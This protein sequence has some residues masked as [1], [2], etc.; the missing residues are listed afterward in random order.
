MSAASDRLLPIVRRMTHRDIDAVSAIEHQSYDFP[1]SSGIFR[2]CIL[3]GYV[4]I[5]LEQEAELR[6]YAILSVAAGEAH[7]LNI[8]VA[9]AFRRRGYAAALLMKLIREARRQRVS[10]M[11]LEV[12]PSNLAA[13][14]L[15]RGLGFTAVGRRKDY[16]KAVGGTREDALVLSLAL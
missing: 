12:R 10:T 4:C 3:A 14:N 15:Y 1:W 8:C 13:T 5:A 7:I 9:P 16:Y 2:D 11:F 6:G